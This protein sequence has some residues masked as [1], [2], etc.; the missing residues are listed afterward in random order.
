MLGHRK[1]S[2]VSSATQSMIFQLLPRRNNANLGCLTGI[3]ETPAKIPSAKSIPARILTIP[4]NFVVHAS[5]GV[6]YVTWDH[7]FGAYD[8]DVQ[9]EIK[10]DKQWIARG[11]LK[12]RYEVNSVIPEREYR[13]RVRACAGRKQLGEWTSNITTIAIQD[14][15][16]MQR[17]LEITVAADG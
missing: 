17:I 3:G 10:G 4:T 14:T 7:V 5:P 12:N 11:E 9:I 16:T 8:Y 2:M 1:A 13:I 6:I 15:N